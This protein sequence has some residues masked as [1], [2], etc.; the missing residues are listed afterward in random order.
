VIESLE[1]LSHVFAS[2]RGLA[3]GR[4]YS[5]GLVSIGMRSNPYGT[6]PGHNAG[7]VRMPMAQID[8]RH[9]GLFAA[10]WAV[11]V[12]AATAGHTIASLALAAPVGPF[13]MMYRRADWPQPIYDNLDA[14]CVFP[15]FHVFRAL[16]QVAQS[17]RLSVEINDD[18]L[19]IVA[20]QREEAAFL[21]VSNVSAQ[22]RALKLPG[23]ALMLTLDQNTFMAAIEDPD[24]LATGP[25]KVGAEIDIAAYGVVF[26]WLG[27]SRT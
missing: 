23:R 13:G 6:A 4:E 10:A 12:V 26:V 14:G 17:P 25:R 2:A 18:N 24:W 22:S 27:R 8:P 21:L 7:Q 15:I 19:K 16:S 3:D 5:L 1:G 20:A 11:G 9:R